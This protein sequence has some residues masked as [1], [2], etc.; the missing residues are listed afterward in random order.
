MPSSRHRRALGSTLVN[1]VLTALAV[2][3]A[4]RPM[5]CSELTSHASNAETGTR[6]VSLVDERANDDFKI[7]LLTQ[8]EVGSTRR[9]EILHQV[10]AVFGRH[11]VGHKLQVLLQRP[12]RPPAHDPSQP[13]PSAADGF[14]GAFVP[15]GF[16]IRSWE[17]FQRL[18][19]HAA[20][21]CTVTF[22]H[23]GRLPRS[24]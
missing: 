15:L 9:G 1:R 18:L 21:A 14:T 8:R 24:L 4:N 10:R 22:P 13:Q 20:T 7:D 11:V 3:P 5:P 17:R 16:R 12:L 19:I 23:P 6:L 2:L